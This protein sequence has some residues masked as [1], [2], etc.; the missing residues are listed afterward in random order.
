MLAANPKTHPNDVTKHLDKSATKPA[1]GAFWKRRFLN[2]PVFQEV[3]TR[4]NHAEE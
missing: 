2:K 4:K 3:Y 1:F